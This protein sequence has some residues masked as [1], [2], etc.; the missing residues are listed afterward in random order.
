MGDRNGQDGI[1]LIAAERT[2]Q[3]VELGWSD[4]HDDEHPRGELSCAAICYAAE[5]GARAD[6]VDEF[7]PWSCDAW[8]PS[9]QNRI[10]EL[11]KAGAL[12]AAEIDRLI[13]F[14]AEG[15]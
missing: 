2:R 13:R 1:D 11:V 14:D 7:W 12:I 10:R 4:Q 5:P 8:R 15:K 3:I 6:L 9:P